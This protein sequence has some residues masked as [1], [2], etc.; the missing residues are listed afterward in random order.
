VWLLVIAVLV[1][2]PV[3]FNLARTKSF[4]ASVQIR[5]HPVGPFAP[6]RAP[7]DYRFYLTTRLLERGMLARAHAEPRQW[8]HAAIQ[9]ASG[10]AAVIVSVGTRSADRARTLADALAA[11]LIAASRRTVAGW[12]VTAIGDA[13][14]RLARKGLS[15]RKLARQRSQLLVLR[16]ISRSGPVPATRGPTV[17]QPSLS[18]ADRLA[19][20]LGAESS[21]PSPLVAGLA[22]ALVGLALWGTSLVLVSRRLEER[23]S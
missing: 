22:G 19:D 11:E 15:R 20:K 1:A 5:P 14:G 16:R 18:W 3:S 10:G 23:T 13:R 4:T 8:A 21:H 7:A 12:T 9:R 17:V 6:I 2:G